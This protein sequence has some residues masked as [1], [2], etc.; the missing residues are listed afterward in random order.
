MDY[1]ITL[2]D[3]QKKAM[4]YVAA[5]V[6]EWITNAAVHRAN[7]GIKQIVALNTAHCNANGIAIA[8]GEAAQVD[9]AYSLEVI[10]TGAQR[11]IDAEAERAAEAEAKT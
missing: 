11:N 3:V 10:K 7:N 8:V 4:E 1:T 2:N 9:Q 5:D 6:D